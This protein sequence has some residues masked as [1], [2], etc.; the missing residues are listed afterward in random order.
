MKVHLYWNFNRLAWSVRAAEGPNRGRVVAYEKVVHLANCQFIVQKAGLEK[1]RATGVKNVH[2]Y[3]KGDWVDAS[4]AANSDWNPI[5]YNPFR[6]GYF[7]WCASG[8]PIER[9][10]GCRFQITEDNRPL[11]EAFPSESA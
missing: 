5:T 10:G 4:I 6:E 7:I 8:N 3:I 11:C 1:A 9:A 2:A